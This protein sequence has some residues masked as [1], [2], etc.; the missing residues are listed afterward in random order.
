[1]SPVVTA[2]EYV[3]LP[4]GLTLKAE[5]VIDY[6]G[7]SKCEKAEVIAGVTIVDWVIAHNML[8]LLRVDRTGMD[9]LVRGTSPAD[10]PEW[11]YL[12]KDVKVSIARD[13]TD[14]MAAIAARQAAEAQM[15]SV[16]H[17]EF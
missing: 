8:G 2:T 13:L 6:G 11:A 4:A 9:K 14:A 17:G 16:P 5:S 1:M 7:D 12:S 10:R 3:T 15:E